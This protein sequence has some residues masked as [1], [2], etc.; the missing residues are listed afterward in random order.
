M[1]IPSML[2]LQATPSII[3]VTT[4][5]IS[6][7]SRDLIVSSASFLSFSFLPGNGPGHSKTLIVGFLVDESLGSIYINLSLK[8]YLKLL[9]KSPAGSITTTT[10]WPAIAVEYIIL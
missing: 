9:A 3:W 8:R 10:A 6:C 4:E 5:Y 1:S 2:A 7:V